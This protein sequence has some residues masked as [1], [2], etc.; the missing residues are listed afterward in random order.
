[1][2]QA[3]PGLIW[4]G[5]LRA[6]QN[7]G[8]LP[9]LPVEPHLLPSPPG[10]VIYETDPETW[11]HLAGRAQEVVTLPTR[12]MRV[13]E[14]GP[15][16]SC[17]QAGG[18]PGE[19]GQDQDWALARVPNPSMGASQGTRTREGCPFAERPARVLGAGSKEEI[20][21]CKEFSPKY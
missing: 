11:C 16:T 18:M 2:G 5:G 19:G 14:E 15:D 13:E 12:S 17:V 1:M 8:P 4:V 3:G 7:P 21:P 20:I 9:E 6:H 10:C